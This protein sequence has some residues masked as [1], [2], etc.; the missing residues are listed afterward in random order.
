MR[1]LTGWERSIMTAMESSV[2]RVALV[3]ATRKI[4]ETNL[5]VRLNTLMS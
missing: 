5:K 3:K 2:G 1:D 4:K